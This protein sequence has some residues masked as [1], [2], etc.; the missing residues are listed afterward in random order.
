MALRLTEDADVGQ[1]GLNYWDEPL[2]KKYQTARSKGYKGV[3]SAFK[4]EFPTG[5]WSP[6]APTVTREAAPVIG[7]RREAPYDPQ[8]ALMDL[9]EQDIPGPAPDIRVWRE[10][11]DSGLPIALWESTDGGETWKKIKDYSG[12]AEQLR[13]MRE[14]RPETFGEYMG[15]RELYDIGGPLEGLRRLAE[16]LSA[17]FTPEELLEAYGGV[18]PETITALGE[19]LAEGVPG[20]PGLGE[21]ARGIYERAGRVDIERMERFAEQQ[22]NAMAAGSESSYRMWMQSDEMARQI[23]DTDIKS[24]LAIAEESYR[25][26][27][28]NYEQKLAYMTAMGA[29]KVDYLRALTANKEAGIQA[30]A[31]TISGMIAQNQQYFDEYA[32]ELQRVRDTVE[33]AYKAIQAELG[34]DEAMITQAEA[35]VDEALRPWELEWEQFGAELAALSVGA[36]LS[37]EQQSAVTDFLAFVSTMLGYAIIAA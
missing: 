36:E 21:E 24:Q 32:L 22:L 23:R 28:V 2:F 16:Q 7:G 14:T 9:L 6:P 4:R 10:Y 35:A 15:D 33:A 11:D 26:Q 18:A 29:S 27:T 13:T 19:E 1:T 31:T 5:G 34:V 12:I 37:A 30:Y 20:Q 25:R 17:G 8:Q 3:Y